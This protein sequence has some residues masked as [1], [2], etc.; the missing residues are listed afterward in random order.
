MYIITSII[1]S[2][3]SF[4]IIYTLANEIS[5]IGIKDHMY[6]NSVIRLYL[7]YNMI[8]LYHLGCYGSKWISPYGPFNYFARQL[9]SGFRWS[10]QILDSL[11]LTEWYEE[12]HLYFSLGL[13][14]GLG[15]TPLVSSL[16]W[17]A[18]FNLPRDRFYS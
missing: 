16:D 4:K 2:L 7:F 14:C 18:N 17:T 1:A 6:V 8:C 10:F 12:A 11:H 15:K 9:T 5:I 13:W 3:I